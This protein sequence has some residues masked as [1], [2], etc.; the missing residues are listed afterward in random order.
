[1][2]V[3]QSIVKRRKANEPWREY[4][5]FFNINSELNDRFAKIKSKN[6]EKAQADAW[7]RYGRDTVGSI[8]SNAEYS[9]NKIK[10]YNLTEI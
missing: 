8:S 2:S 1:M 3:L 4:Y 5:V 7:K 10:L 9:Q 6:V